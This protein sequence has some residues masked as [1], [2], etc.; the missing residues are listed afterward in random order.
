SPQTVTVFVNPPL[1]VSVS[2]PLEICEGETAQISSSASGGDGGPYVYSW[3]GNSILSASAVVVPA[4]DSA[5]TV[6]ISD[7]CSPDVSATV[8]ITVHPLPE[9]EFTPQQFVGCSPVTVQL[10]NVFQVPVG[11]VYSWDL[12]ETVSNEISPTYTYTTPGYYDI[13]LSITTPEGCSDAI[14]VQDAVHV[15]GYPTA[16]F[17][18]STESVSV[19]APSVELQDLSIDAVSWAWDFGD[20]T[21]LFGEQSPTHVYSDSGTFTIQLIV[22][23]DGGCTDTVYGIV[24]IEPEFTIFI[25]NAFTPNGDGKNDFFF[26]VG[27]NIVSIEMWIL[28]RW[29]LE[30]FHSTS[31][32]LQCYG[33][34][35]ANHPSCQN[36]VYEYVV[37]A[38]DLPGRKRRY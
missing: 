22:T 10:S 37:D 17:E 2:S 9:V 35:Y 1:A 15:Y 13:S 23:N 27:E 16:I 32:E 26:P 28:D 7:G 5:F 12:D 30:I 6:T 4:T 8:L 14:A 31:F 24:R 38:V 11:S 20:G 21:V 3:N 34:Y 29:G 25:P 36:D 18:Q 19:F 33:T